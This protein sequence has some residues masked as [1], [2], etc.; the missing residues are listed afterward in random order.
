MSK[1]IFLLEVSFL[2]IVATGICMLMALGLATFFDI[3]E[4]K[5]NQKKRGR[6]RWKLKWHIMFYIV[7]KKV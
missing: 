3:L 1:L 7:V 2:G 6:R 5:R 4:N